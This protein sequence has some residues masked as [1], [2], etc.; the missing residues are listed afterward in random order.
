M[1]RYEKLLLTHCGEFVVSVVRVT[2][3]QA[4]LLADGGTGFIVKIQ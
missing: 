3:G 1:S 2:D 4:W